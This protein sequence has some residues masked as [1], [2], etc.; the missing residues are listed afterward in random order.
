MA[1]HCAWSVAHCPLSSATLGVLTT[2]L[3]VTLRLRV[4]QQAEE[5]RLAASAPHLRHPARPAAGLR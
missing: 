4:A 1:G 3:T 2:L 5:S